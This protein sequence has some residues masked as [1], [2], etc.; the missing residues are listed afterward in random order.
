MCLFFRNKN[1]KKFGAPRFMSFKGVPKKCF[2][3]TAKVLEGPIPGG[4]GGG[5]VL[6]LP[7]RG[8]YKTTKFR[9]QTPSLSATTGNLQIHSFGGFSWNRVST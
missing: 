3:F 5:A 4:G 7:E 8:Y 6:L 1:L 9:L 2:G